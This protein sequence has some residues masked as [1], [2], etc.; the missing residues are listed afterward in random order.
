MSIDRT[1][2]AE[3]GAVLFFID[4][5]RRAHR[6]LSCHQP[7]KRGNC[8]VCTGQLHLTRWPCRIWRLAMA[9]C[10]LLARRSDVVRFPAPRRAAS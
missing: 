6:A 1:V 8:R 10:E 4:D 3:R 7:D 5:L 2:N 9:A